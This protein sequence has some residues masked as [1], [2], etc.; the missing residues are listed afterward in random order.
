MPCFTATLVIERVEFKVKMPYF[1]TD[2]WKK[3]KTHRCESFI[4]K[5][6]SIYFLFFDGT[7]QLLS[8]T[9]RFPFPLD[10]MTHFLFCVTSLIRLFVVVEKLYS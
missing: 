10:A 7:R 1:V 6:D 9:R 4:G 2:E 3:H 5:G 8:F